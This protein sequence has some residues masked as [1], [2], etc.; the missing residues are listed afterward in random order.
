ML[1][2]MLSQQN[3]ARPFASPARLALAVAGVASLLMTACGG[4]DEAS[5]DV[6]ENRGSVCI[7]SEDDGAV[8]VMVQFPTCLSSSCSEVKENTCSV[9]LVSGTI[10]LT[11]RA[12]VE[13]R[14][15]E[16]TTDCG[17]LTAECRSVP[18]QAGTYPI[19]HG[20]DSASV[21]L[22]A[23]AMQVLGEGMVFACE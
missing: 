9:E 17:I 3:R 7:Q 19:V 16:C 5:R 13:Q 1:Q 15:T 6:F 22:P 18:V 11:S 4:D 23:G 10:N 14:G 2:A 12:V 8:S 21:T 20:E